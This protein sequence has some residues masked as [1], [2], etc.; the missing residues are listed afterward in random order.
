M[1]TRKDVALLSVVGLLALSA[2][3]AQAQ[4]PTTGR[5]EGIVKD[6]N[7]AVIPGAEVKILN[8]GTG[9]VRT[10]N[11]DEAGHYAIPLLPPG[12]YRVSISAS[13]FSTAIID[14]ADV[15]ITETTLVN[16]SLVVQ[17]VIVDPIPVRIAPL[18]QTDGPQLGRVVDS[19]MIAEL[20]LASRNFTQILSLSPGV[21]T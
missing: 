12:L 7:G 5:I 20:P 9:D 11:T 18:I 17:G 8:K 6:P 15:L 19:R 13:G 14:A 21:A 1:I 4:S 3:L 10:I 16:A 2:T